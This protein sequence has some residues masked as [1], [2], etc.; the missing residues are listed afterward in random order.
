MRQLTF[1]KPGAFEWRDVPRATL[2]ADTDAIVRPLAVARCDLDLYIAAGFAPYEGPFAFGH[3][4]IA[5]VTDAGKASGVVPG[6]RV[7][8]PFQ[9]SCGRC[10]RC[11]RGHT[12]ACE[13][14]PF[15][16]AYGLKPIDG[17]EFGGA[18]S[19]YMRVPF[20]DHM[21]V[22]LPVGVDPVVAA[23]VC[24]NVA[25][26]WRGVAG[27]LRDRP[28][29]SVLVVGGLAQSVG[30]YAAGS[31]VALGAGRTLYMDDNEDRRARAAALGAETAPLALGDGRAPSERFDIVV[32]AA[33]E[34]AALEFAVRSCAPNGVLTSVAMYFGKTT[35]MPLRH[36]YYQG[37]TFH[38]GRVHARAVLPEP[39][40]CIACGKLH[41]EHVTHR[42]ASFEEAIDAMTDPGPKV[43]FTP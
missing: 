36:A 8:V 6:D 20:A 38:T 23:S 17:V 14:F 35:P 13:A 24:D 37:L 5:E 43:I 16:A 41:V 18:L 3:E 26:G 39:L 30:L 21:L 28:G 25:D 9:L 19:D 15:G 42:V 22:K 34:L 2:Q 11:A 10:A 7:V 29:A 32:D 40:N 12:N 4:A 27:P 31:A 1:L 33:G